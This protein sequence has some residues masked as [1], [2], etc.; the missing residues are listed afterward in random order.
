VFDR[1]HSLGGLELGDT[2]IKKLEEVEEGGLIMCDTS[3]QRNLYTR[4]KNLAFCVT[5]FKSDPFVPM[6]NYFG[7]R[8]FRV[9]SACEVF[10]LSMLLLDDIIQGR[11]QKFF[12]GK[13]E[14]FCTNGKI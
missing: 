4:S 1:D 5:P 6:Q 13:F 2:E 14:F 9:D 8:N 11:I 7:D 10:S 3:I 12:E